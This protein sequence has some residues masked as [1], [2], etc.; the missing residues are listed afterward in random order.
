MAQRPLEIFL[1]K[2]DFLLRYRMDYATAYRGFEWPELTHFNWA[3]DYFDPMAAGNERPALWV[4][5]ENGSETKLSFLELSE[6]SNRVANFLRSTGI[7]RGDRILVMLGNE[8]A[9]WDIMLAAIK[10][11]AVLIPATTLLTPDDLRD[12]LD[13]GQVRQV[14]V[15]PQHR[16][17]R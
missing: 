2:R 17:I 10:L 12:R 9:L 11:G 14:I 1:E 3:L 5:D 6:R 7:K 13:R 4:V 8:V 16:K 15:G